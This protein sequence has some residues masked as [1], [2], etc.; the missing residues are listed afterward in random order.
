MKQ[1]TKVTH[2]L[3]ALDSQ[4]LQDLLLA[5][6]RNQFGS[7]RSNVLLH[8]CKQWNNWAGLA[9]LL[10]LMQQWNGALNARLTQVFA[11]NARELIQLV[12]SS[13]KLNFAVVNFFDSSLLL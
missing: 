11:P 3:D 12:F 5:G 9:C 1:R 13:V 6:L 7:F 10:E 4:H 2:I 8:E